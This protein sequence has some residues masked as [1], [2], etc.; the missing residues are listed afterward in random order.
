MMRA[1]LVP[2]TVQFGGPWT[3]PFSTPPAPGAVNASVGALPPVPPPVLAMPPLML[4]V[5]CALSGLVG[6]VGDHRLQRVRAVRVLLVVD[7]CR[8]RTSWCRC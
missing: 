1:M 7:A 6:G 5:I 3:L 8:C 4:M 2:V